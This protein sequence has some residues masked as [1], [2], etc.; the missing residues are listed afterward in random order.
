V[1]QSFDLFGW[2]KGQYV[3]LN[4]KDSRLSK[5]VLVPAIS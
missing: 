3:T 1:S 4:M 2:G 5:A